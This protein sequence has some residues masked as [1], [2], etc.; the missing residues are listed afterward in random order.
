MKHLPAPTK[1]FLIDLDGVVYVQERLVPGALDTLRLLRDRQI[2][3]RF[4]TNTTS[5]SRRMLLERLRT[6]GLEIPLD[7]LFTAPLA[8]ARHLKATGS[9]R[10]FFYTRPEILEDFDG[11][12]QV[13]EHPTHVVIGD[14]GERFSYANMNAV[15]RMIKG[16]AEIIA[17]QKNRYWLTREGL[18]LDAGA[19]ISALEFATEKSALVFG[20]PSASFF[21]EACKSLG[22]APAEVVMIGDD[23]TVDIGGAQTA[24]LQTVF[25]RTG[26][27]G[28]KALGPEGI[29]PTVEL[30]SIASLT[31]LIA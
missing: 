26:K 12:E 14:V 3:H 23:L 2:P 30:P 19:F 8:A 28:D 6:A 7:H 24:G 10:C 20:K 16:G 11:L 18:V 31:E 27:D 22:A 25:V 21:H 4:V 9:A 13:T 15:F 29:Q 1:A 5:I 17:F